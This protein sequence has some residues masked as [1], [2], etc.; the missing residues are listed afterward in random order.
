VTGKQ[1]KQHAQ[2]TSIDSIELPLRIS[3]GM[4]R[5]IGS[6]MI[7]TPMGARRWRLAAGGWR[8]PCVRPGP[9]AA[10]LRPC[11]L[12]WRCGGGGGVAVVVVQGGAPGCAAGRCCARGGAVAPASL[13]CHHRQQAST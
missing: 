12:W 9:P 11:E 2:D 1:R 7:V 10:A 6:M 13:P 5:A 4:Q 3:R 8:L